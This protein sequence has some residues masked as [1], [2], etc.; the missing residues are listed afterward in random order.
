MIKKIFFLMICISSFAFAQ[1]KARILRAGNGKIDIRGSIS[2]S[3]WP[4]GFSLKAKA[5]TPYKVQRI[6]ESSPYSKELL[7]SWN[8]KNFIDPGSLVPGFEFENFT[9][10]VHGLELGALIKGFG[11]NNGLDE[12][13]NHHF[14]D[15]SPLGLDFIKF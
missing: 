1:P 15:E 14:N 5:G 4:E 10:I 6:A 2:T 7:D 3:Q 8:P 13:I 12:F 9:F 11:G